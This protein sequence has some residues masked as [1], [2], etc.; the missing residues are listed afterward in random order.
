MKGAILLLCGLALTAAYPTWDEF[1]GN[2]KRKYKNSTEEA[3]RKKVFEYNLQIIK[4]HRKKNATFELAMNEFGDMTSEEFGAVM[5]GFMGESPADVTVLLTAA[6][7]ATPPPTMDWRTKGTVTP[8]K[9]QLQ[10]GSCW[11]FSAVSI[12]GQHF[13][14]TGK[15]VSLSEQQLVECS[16]GT[17]KNL[18]CRGGLMTSAFNYIKATGADSGAFYPYVAVEGPCKFSAKNIAATLTGFASVTSKS[19]SALQTAAGTIGP[20][21][22]AIDASHSSFQ[23]Y[24]SGVYY[25]PACSSTSLNHGALVVGYGTSPAGGDYWI[26]KNSWGTG[27]GE[28]GYIKMARNKNNN[29]GIATAASYPTV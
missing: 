27:W 5:N 14:K 10:C 11:A 25:E 4:D 19:E 9:N 6:T 24:K 17:Y 21:S 12:M 15:L 13:R 2:Y 18:G 20:I 1:K 8:V 29:C 26:V 7:T 16:G 22:V 23:F 3:R 28:A